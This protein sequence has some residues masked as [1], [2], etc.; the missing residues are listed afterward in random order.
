M[1]NY[2]VAMAVSLN[3]IRKA[4]SRMLVWPPTDLDQVRTHGCS[5]Q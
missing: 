2:P 5:L 3:V 4:D 1:G